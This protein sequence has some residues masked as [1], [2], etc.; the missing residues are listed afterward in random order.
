MQDK[1]AKASGFSKLVVYGIIGL[2]LVV[3]PAVS[4]IYLK[5]GFKWRVQAQSELQDY[6]KIRAAL[7][8]IHI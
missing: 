4:Y 7:S 3:F 8:L 6:G 2:L 1:E 5:D